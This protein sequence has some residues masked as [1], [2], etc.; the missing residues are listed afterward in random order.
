MKKAEK[1]GWGCITI[2]EVCIVAFWIFG[3]N[4]NLK[5]AE[6]SFLVAGIAALVALCALGLQKLR[7]HACGF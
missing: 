5:A 4:N 3:F 6:V 7:N 1:F 2:A